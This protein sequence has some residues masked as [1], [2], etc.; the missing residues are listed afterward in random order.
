MRLIIRYLLVIKIVINE[1]KAA[2]DRGF[3][4]KK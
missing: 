1:K 2:E 4:C 3:H